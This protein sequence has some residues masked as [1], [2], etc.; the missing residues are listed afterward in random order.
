MVK[1]DLYE[2]DNFGNP[3]IYDDADSSAIHREKKENAACLT[4][5]A[6]CVPLF[7]IAG[8]YGLSDLIV[9]IKTG[10]FHLTTMAEMFMLTQGPVNETGW[11]SEILG[12]LPVAII[13]FLLGVFV[14]FAILELF[15]KLEK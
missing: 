9:F 4:A 15:F 6:F 7:M 14:P 10:V 1:L 5:L 13:F 8:L 3:I 2:N 12:R 11:V